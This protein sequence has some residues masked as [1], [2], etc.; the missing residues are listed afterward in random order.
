MKVGITGTRGFLGSA[1]AETLAA[2]GHEVVSLDRFLRAERPD[3]TTCPDDVGWV[4]HFAARTSIVE[5]FNQPLA[6]Y[7]ANLE[8]TLRAIEAT[9]HAGAAL[10]LVSSYVYG[11]PRYNPI[12]TDHPLAAE[13]PYMAS[14]LAC[15]TA[16]QHFARLL[17]FPLLI[18]RPF[19]IF[20]GH[21][22]PGRLI[23]DLLQAAR[24]GEPLFVND[25]DVRRDYVY[26]RD[27]CELIGRIVERQPPAT[28]VFNVGSGTPY[29]NLEVAQ[30]VGRLAGDARPVEVRHRPRPNDVAACWAEIGPLRETFGWTPRY[31]L[32]TALEELLQ[33]PPAVR[34]AG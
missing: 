27:F 33:T 11:V 6:F 5:S 10:L 30:L 23:S 2:A 32:P 1:V 21:L 12:D 7:R 18:L 29:T 15:E 28:G 22:I 4:L 25:P 9:R 13:N 8:S 34:R 24:N 3:V 31:T 26:V 16:G 14:K 19:H 20:G 17:K